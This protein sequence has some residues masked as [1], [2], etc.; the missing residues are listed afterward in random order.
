MYAQ[1]LPILLI[2]GDEQLR[3]TMTDYFRHHG[4]FIIEVP[5]IEQGVVSI[6][7]REFSMVIVDWNINGTEAAGFCSRLRARS[8]QIPIIVL[9]DRSDL[10]AQ[11][12]AYTYDVD[13]YWPKPYPMSLAVA[14][15][16]VLLR[17]THVSLTSEDPFVVG[18]AIV[19]LRRR[20]ITKNGV[21]AT[22]G[23]KE[24]GIL[25]LLVFE[26]G[27]PVRREILLTSVWG[28]D[29]LP[30]SRTVDNYIVSLRRKLEDDP[31][32]PMYLLTVGGIGYRLLHNGIS[33]SESQP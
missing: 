27:A 4:L 30:M 7:E 8:P 11:L 24:Y 12:E 17:R 13:D 6:G 10:D 28:F 2:E 14:K 23:D 33:S 26:E 19:D 1:N 22:L 15:V 25:R 5:S 29:S 9:S 20:T 16:R 31:K 32:R 21:I 18:S 3:R